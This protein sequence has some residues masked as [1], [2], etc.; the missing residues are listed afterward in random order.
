[1]NTALEHLTEKLAQL[2]PERI[3]EVVD[4]VDFIAEREHDR[5]IVRTAQAASET[6]LA[7][8]WNNDADAAYDRL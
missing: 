3:A 7:S 4:F 2:P 1:M 6:T 8:I 5:R